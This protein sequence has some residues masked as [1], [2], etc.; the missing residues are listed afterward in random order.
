MSPCKKCL[1]RPS[2]SKDCQEFSDY[3]TFCSSIM[4]LFAIMFAGI[5]IGFLFYYLGVFE[6]VTP[7][8]TSPS[9]MII[10]VVSIG[11]SFIM[12]I[13]TEEKISDAPIII[14]APFIFFI[15]IYLYLLAFVFTRDIRKRA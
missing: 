10:W 14:F 3:S 1:I 5:S 15:F 11:G 12:N 6:E 7:N 13:K 4:S 8:Y 9:L 2:C